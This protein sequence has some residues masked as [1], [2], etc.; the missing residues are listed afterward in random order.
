[1]STQRCRQSRDWLFSPQPQRTELGR[2]RRF[3]LFFRGRGLGRFFRS[4][5]D[6]PLAGETGNL[7]TFGAGLK[8]AHHDIR[9]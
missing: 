6:G 5:L 1:M 9:S 2:H 8:Q 3:F 4:G 7:G